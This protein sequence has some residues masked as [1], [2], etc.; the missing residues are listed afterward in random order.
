VA[1][2]VY[3]VATGAKFEL[4]ETSLRQLSCCSTTQTGNMD[5]RFNMLNRLLQQQF[6]EL[7]ASLSTIEEHSKQV[8]ESCEYIEGEY[9]ESRRID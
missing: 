6:D 2:W 7:T 5:G 1:W 3:A 9:R 4:H 8:R